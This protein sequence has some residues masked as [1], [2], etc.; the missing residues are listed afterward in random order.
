MGGASGE[1]AGGGGE[2][3]RAQAQAGEGARWGWEGGPGPAGAGGARGGGALQRRSHDGGL[4]SRGRMPS[5][6]SGAGGA[7]GNARVETSDL[8]EQRSSHTNR[9]RDGPGAWSG[10]SDPL[11][12]DGF[13][14]RRSGY[15]GHG[16]GHVGGS[17]RLSPGTAA[18]PG[19]AS[20]MASARSP[21]RQV[22]AMRSMGGPARALAGCSCLCMLAAYK[23]PCCTFA[24]ADIVP[25]PIVPAGSTTLLHLHGASPAWAD[26]AKESQ[27]RSAPQVRTQAT[28]SLF[29]V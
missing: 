16:E 7:G 24:R 1:A 28:S 2:A 25:R 12:R 13:D 6:G 22:R 10:R 26:T 9:M 11:E 3:P 20:R 5:T 29:T 8:Y 18:A 19:R 21:P 15:G 17:A 14:G 23:A 27:L 4:S